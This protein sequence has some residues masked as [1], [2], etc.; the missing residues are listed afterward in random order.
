VSQDGSR[1]YYDLQ[2]VG[3]GE[4][5]QPLLYAIAAEQ[6]T[7]KS[8]L[9]A[10]L[11]YSTVRGGFEEEF[12]YVNSRTRGMLTEVLR[13]IDDHLRQGLLPAAPRAAACEYCDYRPICG[14]YEEERTA[15]KPQLESLES[16]RRLR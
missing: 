14:P 2:A 7:G 8:V 13:T 15:R 4:T 10:R 11:S 6:L 1:T 9:E 3:A 16:I 5:L 12:V